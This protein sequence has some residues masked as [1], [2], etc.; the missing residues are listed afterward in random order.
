MS[1]ARKYPDVSQLSALEEEIGFSIDQEMIEGQR[2]ELRR[3][4]SERLCSNR[5]DLLNANSAARITRSASPDSA[6]RN[7]D[8]NLRKGRFIE[9]QFNSEEIREQRRI[10]EMLQAQRQDIQS[11]KDTAVKV[12][13]VNATRTHGPFLYPSSTTDLDDCVGQ[14]RNG[15]KVRVTSAKRVYKDISRGDAILVECIN[16]ST[17]LQVGKKTV[18]V[19][20]SVCQ[21]I[22][23]IS[24]AR[25][26]SVSPQIDLELASTLQIQEKDAVV[27]RVQDKL[28]CQ[29]KPSRGTAP[30]STK[31]R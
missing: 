28:S 16:C 5:Q 6:C 15:K 10:Y 23:P 21:S 17:F 20:C 29:G 7:L 24:Q 1:A 11:Q 26:Q 2:A 12:T 25:L 31:Y 22:S 18:N 14:L 8:G 27:A 13:A 4:Q 30:T 9:M 19:F 3:I